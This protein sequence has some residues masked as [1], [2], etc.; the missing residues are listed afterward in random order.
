MPNVDA[1]KD[2]TFIVNL[3][4]R[5]KFPSETLAD[6]LQNLVCAFKKV[7]GFRQVLCD[8]ILK[9]QPAF[10]PFEI[11]NVLR[12]AT[13]MDKFAILP[14]CARVNLLRPLSS[15][16][17]HPESPGGQRKIRRCYDRCIR[18]SNSREDQAQSGLRE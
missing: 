10:R 9:G 2:L 18:L 13:C 8:R 16:S 7:I 3:P 5:S 1:T 12:K 15:V 6:G 11:R 14:E 17:G 4:E